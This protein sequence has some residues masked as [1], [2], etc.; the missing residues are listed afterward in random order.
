[1]VELA[2]VTY[3]G[4]TFL[5]NDKNLVLKIKTDDGKK[6]IELKRPEGREEAVL[7]G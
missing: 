5:N 4:K 3:E 1:M 7:R 2:P 6:S